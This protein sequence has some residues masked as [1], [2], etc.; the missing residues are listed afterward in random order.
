MSKDSNFY[1]DLSASRRRRRSQDLEMC[2]LALPLF[3]SCRLGLFPRIAY[4]SGTSISLLP[5]QVVFTTVRV[6]P[7]RLINE[8]CDQEEEVITGATSDANERGTRLTYQAATELLGYT[9][10]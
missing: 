7:E 8:A 10:A 3:W 1:D 2:W 9:H 6:S 4:K 5:T